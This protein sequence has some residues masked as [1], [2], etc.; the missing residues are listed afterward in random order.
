[1]ISL[2]SGIVCLLL[3]FIILMLVLKNYQAW[4]YPAETLPEKG[5]APKT[6]MKIERPQT[7]G[8]QKEPSS[9]EAY[10]S[11]AE[12]NIFSPERREFS[13]S[14][15]PSKDLSKPMVRPKIILYGVTLAGDYQS[16]SISNPGRPLKKGEREI[17]SVKIGD[18]IGEYKVTEILP[19]R[20]IMEAAEDSFE[21]LLYDPKTPKQ[22]TYAKTETKPTTITS[23]L[24]TPGVAPVPAPVPPQVAAGAPKEPVAGAVAAMPMPR[25]ITAAPFPRSPRTRRFN[26]P[27][28]RG[29]REMDTQ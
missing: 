3:C 26:F 10:V 16:A 28:P 29:E 9:I 13:V 25:R 20:I 8:G 2:R 4:N 19:D 6:E 14:P 12:N 1:M 23:T 17:M 18:R 24:P 7:A 27:Q 22:R 21:V 5:R 11:I 15:D